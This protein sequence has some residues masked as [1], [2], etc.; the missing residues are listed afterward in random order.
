MLKSP[1]HL[2]ECADQGTANRRAMHWTT[3]GAYMVLEIVLCFIPGPAVMAV[4]GAAFGHHRAGFATALGILTGNAAYFV[5]SALGIASVILASHTAF[6]VVKW[7]GAAYLAYL[8]IRA[9]ATD[10]DRDTLAA[11]PTAGELRRSWATGTITQLANP[12]ALVFFIAILPQFI[13]PHANL[14]LQIAVLGVAGLAI[15]L[16]V[17]STYV[18][19]ADRIRR[20]GIAPRSR[21]L[22]ER[23]GGV[24]LIGVAAAVLREPT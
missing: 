13:D 20:R 7:C 1:G 3:L 9:L 12:K 14:I 21:I 24:F 2:H 17:L 15:E 18:A 5:I 19:A 22:A 11:I 23:I 16:G 10:S 8:G 4:V 6:V